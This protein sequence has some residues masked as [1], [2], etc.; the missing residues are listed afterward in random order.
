MYLCRYLFLNFAAIVI[1]FCVEKIIKFCVEV[2]F[3]YALG[4]VL[5]FAL[6][7]RLAL[8]I[9]LCGVTIRRRGATRRG[10]V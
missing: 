3:H 5:H 6:L 1:T 8:V 4:K 7:L 9:T 10:A 2:L